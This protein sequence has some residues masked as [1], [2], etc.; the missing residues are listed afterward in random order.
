MQEHMRKHLRRFDLDIR[1]TKISRYFD[2]KTKIDVV[3]FLAECVLQLIENDERKK[4]TIKDVWKMDYFVKNV[5]DWFKK[6]TPDDPKAKNEY[7]KF[8]SQPLL[9]LHY[10]G[11]LGGIKKRSWEFHCEDKILLEYVSRNH[12]KAHE[13]LS[14]YY[15]KV[16]NDSGLGDYLEEF[17]KQQNNN[18][19]NLLKT[20][21]YNL[22]KEHT[23]VGNT[24]ATGDNPGKTEC[25]RMLN[26]TLNIICAKRNKIGTKSG[27][28][29]DHVIMADELA[30]NRINFRDLKKSKAL[31]RKQASAIQVPYFDH[32]ESQAKKTMKKMYGNKPMFLDEFYHC[33]QPQIHHIIPKNHNPKFAGYVENMINLSPTQHTD[34]AHRVDGK[35]HTN[36]INIGYQRKLLI[37]KSFYI[38][39]SLYNGLEYYS[40][41]DFI[42][43]LNCGM[44]LEIS[45]KYSFPKI[46]N[47]VAGDHFDLQI[48]DEISGMLI[49]A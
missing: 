36:D 26:P 23:P 22:M 2:Q 10:S 25:M 28:L 44:D 46:R 13:F 31:T 48:I 16:L 43:L 49:I 4:F 7:D 47:V 32:E 24:Y 39:K 38:E 45:E 1:K 20:Q 14:L 33:I 9:T 27:R 5:P 37:A 34:K 11:L 19:L 40:K 21:F 29:A 12:R 35:V 18:T 41:L 30:Y 6:P 3:T 8:V 17:L 15:T 42:D